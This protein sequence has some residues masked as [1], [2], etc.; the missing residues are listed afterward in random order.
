MAL[1]A[2]LAAA[3]VMWF[4]LG[5]CADDSPATPGTTTG[6]QVGVPGTGVDVTSGGGSDTVLSA[7][8]TPGATDTP[9]ANAGGDGAGSAPSAP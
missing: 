5:G 4:G 7:S 6:E 1:L 9:N 8:T 3:A 2:T